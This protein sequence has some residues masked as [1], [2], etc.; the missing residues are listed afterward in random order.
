LIGSDGDLNFVWITAFALKDADAN[1][2]GVA[3]VMRNIEDVRQIN[4]GLLDRAATDPLTG[5][6]NRRVLENTVAVEAS[7]GARH[8]HTFSMLMVDIDQ[9]KRYND[10]HGPTAGDNALRFTADILNNGTRAED[11]VIRLI[12]DAFIIIAPETGRA[13]ALIIADRL[14]AR[15]R[16]ISNMTP[17]L[18]GRVS[19]SVGVTCSVN[20]EVADAARLLDSLYDALERAK[21]TGGNRTVFMPCEPGEACKR[22]IA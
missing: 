2:I 1:V 11:V 7:R 3:E 22:E 18:E 4:S 15:I 14:R 20:G 10:C 13:G 6:W 8:R 19:V 16:E 9:F 12:G 17:H 21:T 5:L